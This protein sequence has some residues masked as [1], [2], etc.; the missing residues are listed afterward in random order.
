MTTVQRSQ[1]DLL[2][3]LCEI[4]RFRHIF[5]FLNMFEVGR[6]DIAF[7]N[8]E[9]RTKYLEHIKN[10]FPDLIFSMDKYCIKNSSFID[11][12][13]SRDIFL[14]HICLQYFPI[15]P[16]RNNR[17]R[18]DI[19]HNQNA[20]L[21]LG[22]FYVITNKSLLSLRY[23]GKYSSV[24][25]FLFVS[26]QYLKYLDLSNCEDLFNSTITLWINTCKN[27]ESISLRLDYN[28]Q[29]HFFSEIANKCPKLESVSLYMQ[30]RNHYDS[31]DDIIYFLESLSEI[32][33]LVLPGG[34]LSSHAVQFIASRFFKLQILHIDGGE[35]I[36]S[37]NV[38]PF[39]GE[40]VE[41]ITKNC[42]NLQELS[43]TQKQNITD[44]SIFEIAKNCS[45]KLRKLCLDGCKKL[46]D[47]SV[48]AV[49]DL[50][51]NLQYLSLSN[52]PKLSNVSMK[53]I[54]CCSNLES[55]ILQ[56][57]P[58]ITNR[59]V[60]AVGKKCTSLRYI[61]VNNCVQL[62]HK[63]MVHY[64][65][66]T[67]PEI[68]IY[69]LDKLHKYVDNEPLSEDQITFATDIEKIIEKINDDFGI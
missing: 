30:Q 42:L 16:K 37:V 19:I 11:W 25:D 61:D 31:I 43:L 52:L 14:Q 50:C 22:E 26:C 13:I 28:I 39:T 3:L 41:L 23:Q 29:S 66:R 18:E 36:D 17:N 55:I 64:L 12:I 27:L 9:I 6:V 4:S 58:R 20:F 65:L 59:F 34:N 21:K 5:Q 48:I 49:V 51:P 10:T 54:S 53:Y 60:A 38:V 35:D 8:H 24:L 63:L 15:A 47:A 2:Y 32:K 68:E 45:G 69:F 40:D 46:T 62:T 56:K 7:N 57:N 33:C 44:K 1:V 67:N